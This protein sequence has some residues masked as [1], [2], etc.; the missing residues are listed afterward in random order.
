MNRF[1]ARLVIA[2]AL[3]LAVGAAAA[4]TKDEAQ[5]AGD[6]DIAANGDAPS[7]AVGRTHNCAN[8]YPDLARRRGQSGDVLVGYDVG[9]DGAVANVRVV[10]SSGYPEL[11]NAALACVASQW[12]NTPALRRGAP[13]ATPDHRAI[14]RFRLQ[15]GVPFRFNPMTLVGAASSMIVIAVGLGIVAFGAVLAWLLERGQRRRRY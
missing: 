2:A 7:R 8:Y 5:H 14:I 13:V 10:K 3:V 4:E 12:R 6:T 15:D 9:A 1:C 11:D